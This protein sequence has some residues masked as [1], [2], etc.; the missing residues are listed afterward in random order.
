MICESMN[1]GNS[2]F[3]Q[4]WLITALAISYFLKEKHH[5]VLHTP[6]KFMP[7]SVLLF[8]HCTA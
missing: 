6:L 4:K 8:S 1:K 3:L 5:S 2:S 7:P